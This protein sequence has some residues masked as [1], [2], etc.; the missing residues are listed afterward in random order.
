MGNIRVLVT[1]AASGIGKGIAEKFLSQGAKVILLDKDE[2]KLS[3]TAKELESST[4]VVESIICDLRNEKELQ[5]SIDWTWNNLGG[6]DVLVNNAGL[7]I[8]ESFVDIP[9]STWDQ[10]IDVN[11]RAT[12]RLSQI[13]AKRMIEDKV[14]GSIVNISSKNG[15]SGSSKLAH[16]NTSKA[17][18]NLLTQSM[19]VELA[20]YNIRVNAVAPGFIDT[21]LDRELKQKE[22]NLKLTEKT[23]MNRLGTVQE[24]ANGV[25]FLASHQASYITGTTLII[26]GGHLANASEF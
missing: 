11:L 8:R 26:D 16:Y 5:S 22:N 1:G 19:A 4:E 23:P 7:A 20:T 2:L 24:V 17:G 14:S 10:I 12:F 25:Y 21:P 13:V 6:L 15:I 18:I 3:E 9:L